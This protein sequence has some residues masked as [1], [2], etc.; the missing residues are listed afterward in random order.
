M[1][2]RAYSA[3]QEV[4][5]VIERFPNASSNI[6]LKGFPSGSCSVVS[7]A[8]GTLLAQRYDEV[9]SLVSRSGHR[10]LT[11]TWLTIS[12]PGGS[13]ASIDATVQQFSDVAAEPF[14][15][16]GYSPSHPAFPDRLGNGIRADA[17]PA[18][19][20]HGQTREVYGW[21]FP[22]LGLSLPKAGFG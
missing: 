15:G 22:L 9:W 18:W 1:T 2:V 13:N 21:A 7:F 11:H 5:A 4:V 16:Y 6:W 3:V 20:H 14:V 8:I 12:L 10:G 19:W 17:V